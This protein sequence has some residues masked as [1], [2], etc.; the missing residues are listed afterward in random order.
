MSRHVPLYARVVTNSESRQAILVAVFILLVSGFLWMQYGRPDVTEPRSVVKEVQRLNQLATV[1]YTIQRVVTLTEPKQP[2]GEERI[3]LIVQARVEAG[4]DLASLKQN[5]FTRRSDGSFTIRLPQAKILNVSIDEKQT[6]VWDREKTWW[7]PWVS[8]SM[9]L[10]QRARM[11]GLEEARKAAIES[12]ILQQAQQNAE[13]S[14]RILIEAIT[15]K[16]V[17]VTNTGAS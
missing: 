16:P 12:G 8:Y 11:Q 17:L 3:L 14:V 9:D 15:Q 1:R 10:E 7:T 4:V 5:D 13:S 2:V 6:R